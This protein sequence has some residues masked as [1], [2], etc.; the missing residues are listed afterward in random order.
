MTKTEER[1][2]SIDFSDPYL[3]TGL[4]LLIGR[5]S[6]VQTGD[7]LDLPDRTIAVRQGT[8]G[9]AYARENLTQAN[10]LA[11]EKESSAVLEVIQGKAD[12]FIYDQM[13]VWKYAQI[14][15]GE[16]RAQLQ[17][18]KRESWAIG[19]RQGNDALRDE[20]NSFLKAFKASEGFED[21]GD[22]YLGDQKAAFAKAG[23][24]FYF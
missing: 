9:E 20:V 16:T 3:S 12:A 4:A 8:T 21:L 5:N 19:I 14:H 10:V 15:P 13:S 2:E 18:V 22:K 7:D 6:P 23:I 17:P 1:A 24:P 11:L